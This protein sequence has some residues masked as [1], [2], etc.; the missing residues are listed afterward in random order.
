MEITHHEKSTEKN[1]NT[2]RNQTLLKCK[3]HLTVDNFDQ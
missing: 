1:M 2:S 3:N